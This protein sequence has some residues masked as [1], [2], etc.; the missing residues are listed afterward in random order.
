VTLG[1]SISRIPFEK[2][3]IEEE[4]LRYNKLPAVNSVLLYEDEKGP[5]AA[6]KHVVV[7]HG[8]LLYNQRRYPA[9]LKR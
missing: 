7:H 1:D 5:V 8:P 9:R 4:E 6:K 2:K 3:R